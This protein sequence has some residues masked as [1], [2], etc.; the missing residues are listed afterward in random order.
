MIGIY[1]IENQITK[2]IYIGSCSNFNVR[3]GSHL[4]LLRQGKHH[5]II[6]QRAF[7]KYTQKSFT[8]SLIE[9]CNKEDLIQRE[10]Y[11]IDLLKPKYNICPIAGSTLNRVLT[12]E[13]KQNLSKS[14][15]GKI[16]TQEQKENQRQ[17]KLGKTHTIQTKEKV[18]KIVNN[19]KGNRVRDKIKKENILKF[20]DIANI[21]SS[22][23]TI[24]QICKENNFNYRSVLRFVSN[25]TWKEYFHLLDKN[26]IANFKNPS[27]TKLK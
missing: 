4:C 16:R 6:L 13:H 17:I 3:K 14:L 9:T 21:E 22:V 1:K 10:Q 8:I 25:S 19:I 7:D 11:Y 15:T 27:L 20:V 26:T 18:S 23:K 12:E 24:K 5:S 2:D